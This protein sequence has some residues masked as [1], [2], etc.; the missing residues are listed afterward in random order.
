MLNWLLED[1]FDPD[2]IVPK[3]GLLKWNIWCSAPTNKEPFESQIE[4]EIG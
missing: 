2:G 4:S 3:G 1:V